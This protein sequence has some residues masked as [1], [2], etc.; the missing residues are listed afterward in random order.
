[1]TK[2]YFEQEIRN[3]LAK[4]PKSKLTQGPSVQDKKNYLDLK[5]QSRTIHSHELLH[6]GK[7]I[8]ILHNGDQYLLRCTRNGKLILTK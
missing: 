2:Q 6:Q 1:M 3:K 7:E 5:N 4:K 8:F